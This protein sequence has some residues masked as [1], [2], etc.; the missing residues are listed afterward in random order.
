[1]LKVEEGVLGY[2][3]IHPHGH[4]IYIT[5]EDDG[6]R[7]VNHGGGFESATSAT[8]KYRHKNGDRDHVLFTSAQPLLAWASWELME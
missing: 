8:A 5:E 7:V 2:V 3:I 1:M 4:R 6:I